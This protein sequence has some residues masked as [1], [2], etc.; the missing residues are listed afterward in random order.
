MNDKHLLVIVGPTAAGKT[1]LTIRLAREHGAVVISADSRQ[2]FREMQIGT[3]RPTPGE[4]G[5][6]PHFFLGHLSVTEYY[7]AGKFELD[8]LE[9][10]ENRFKSD[11]IVFMSGG[12]GMYI[13]AVC[14][15]IDESPPLDKKIRD[16]IIAEYNTMG[17]EKMLKRLE[18]TDPE[19]YQRVDKRNPKR[20]M[21]A[22]EVIEQTGR[23]YSNIR[24]NR[25]KERPFSIHKL[26][27]DIPREV[28]YE[29]INSRVD[30]MIEN[31]LVE[32]ASGLYKY[33][34]LDCLRTVGYEELFDFFDG[35]TSLEESIRLIKR[36]TRR[37]AKRQLTWFRKDKEM[38]WFDPRRTDLILDFI[39]AKIR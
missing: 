26:G 4:T 18:E 23:P 39:R 24:K 25:F 12:S 20:I 35:R 38:L 22:L 13:D 10:L 21:R 34:D 36:N 28:L 33:R 31:G 7:S 9:F 17:K 11:R 3:S 19:Y 30:R 6:V 37:Y 32:E 16:R 2:F 15:G 29:R 8:V 27:I 14:R 1:E 5:E